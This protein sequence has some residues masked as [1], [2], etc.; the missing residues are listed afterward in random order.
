MAP[1]VA[2]VTGGLR[3][4]GRAIAAAL[5]ESGFDLAIVDRD[6]EP[7]PLADLQKPNNRVAY[8]RCDLNEAGE[9]RSV[10]AAILAHFEQITCLVNNAGIAPETRRP[11]GEMTVASYDR[12]MGVNLRGTVFFTQAVLLA[13]RLDCIVNISSVSAAM[14]TPDRLEYCLSK[15]GIAAFTQALALDLAPSGTSVF[16]VRPGIIRTAMTEAVQE[17][18]D[19]VIAA[20]LVPMRRWGKPSDI[21][22]IVAGLAGGQFAFATGSVIMADGGLS[23]ARI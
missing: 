20:G 14:T 22:A 11:I 10:V 16:E 2:I 18:Y 23:I 17:R 12:V 1:R 3:G 9:H 7:D 19:P 5:A 4:I 15:A 8:F 6:P 21:G 13:A